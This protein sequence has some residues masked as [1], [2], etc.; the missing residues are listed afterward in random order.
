MVDMVLGEDTPGYRAGE[1]RW[2][3]PWPGYLCVSGAGMV[4]SI[5]R[6]LI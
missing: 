3:C 1:A 5:L 6:T 2:G 4:G